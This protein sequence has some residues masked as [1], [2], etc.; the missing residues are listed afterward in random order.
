MLTPS[1]VKNKTPLDYQPSVEDLKAM[2]FDD[3]EIYDIL[4]A[5]IY[6][7]YGNN[8]RFNKQALDVSD[9][10]HFIFRPVSATIGKLLSSPMEKQL[11]ISSETASLSNKDIADY[12]EFMKN[13]KSLKDVGV[14]L[15]SSHL[16]DRLD[17]TWKNPDIGVLD[18]TFNTVFSPV[19]NYSI[20]M[21]RSDHYDPASKTVTL[22]HADPAILAH[23][24]GH[25]VDFGTAKDK[26]LANALYM[27]KT[28]VNQEYIASNLALN[29][30]AKQLLSKKDISREDLD[31]IKLRAK[32]LRKAFNTYRA[33]VGFKKNV[34]PQV[35]S[36]ISDVKT[37]D[38]D[39]FLTDP[40]LYNKI[41]RLDKKF[42]KEKT[43]MH[44][45]PPYHYLS[46]LPLTKQA[47][48]F[49]DHKG[50][51]IGTLLGGG[52][53]TGLTFALPAVGGRDFSDS[54]KLK[55]VL[56]STAAGFMGGSAYDA[57]KRMEEEF[58]QFKLDNPDL[59]EDQAQE[60]F[61]QQYFG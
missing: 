44:S 20:A 55:N 4:T 50:K 26:Q 29:S 12:L 7:Q 5:T 57:A 60:A 56:Y 18:K 1:K 3:E 25:A 36:A 16:M 58:E 19:S 8:S 48:F 52:L 22:F 49:G 9:K 23:E 34:D 43:A 61:Q 45:L 59:D 51:L 24:L 6:H 10:E 31:K 41:R 38:L 40:K 2:G 47:G 13:R 14:H 53:G 33:A 54:A 42:T 27:M 37:P 39:F 46:P 11:G 15:G 17:R 30:L 28:P 35:L 32:T 21:T